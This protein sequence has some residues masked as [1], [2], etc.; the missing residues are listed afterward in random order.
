MFFVFN[1]EKIYAYIVS[2]VTVILL[3]CTANVIINNK[4]KSIPTSS[5][6]QKLLP[7][8]NVQTQD[9]KVALTMNCAW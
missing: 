5:N 6:S 4:E 9:N 7:I 1:K 2:V 8:Y 3:F